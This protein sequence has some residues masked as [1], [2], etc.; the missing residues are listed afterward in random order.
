VSAALILGIWRRPWRAL[1]RADAATR[2]LAGLMGGVLAVMNASFYTAIDHLPLGTVAA[3]EFLP[4][5]GLAALGMRTARNAAALG[6]AAC[7]VYALT[8]AHL[9]GTHFTGGRSH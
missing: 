2:R 3:I 8:D 7:G 5:I 9:S 6:L 1:S 4:V